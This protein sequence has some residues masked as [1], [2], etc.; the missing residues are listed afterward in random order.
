ML[1][2]AVLVLGCRGASAGDDRFSSLG[3][4]PVVREVTGPGDR[5]TVFRPA[6]PS[7]APRPVVVFCVG[8]GGDAGS[9]GALLT[10]W[11]S[12]G[13]F[14][15]AGDDPN[16]AGGDQA[17]EGIAWLLEQSETAGSPY[18]GAV[19]ASRVAVAGHSQG[20]NAAMHVALRG[21]ASSVL[22]IQPGRG[23]LGGAEAAD[24]SRLAAPIFYVCGEGDRIVPPAWCVERF[25]GTPARAWLGVLAGANHFAPVGREVGTDH[26]ELRRWATRWLYARLE[27]DEE[28]LAGFDTDP[29]ELALDPSW[30][31]VRRR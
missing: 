6:E 2:A 14:V 7:G 15:I 27:S 26:V 11:A 3:P 28:A 20:G 31:D 30:V 18:E 4:A 5:F 17:M 25:E 13:F 24:E 29:F 9:Y 12:H 23:E 10:H 19:D 22:A 16:Q 21:G 8:T 1:L